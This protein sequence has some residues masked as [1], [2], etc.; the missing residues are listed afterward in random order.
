MSTELGAT[1]TTRLLVFPPFRFDPATE[2]LWLGDER[3]PLRPKTRA[4]LVYL[5]E[6]RHRIVSRAELCRAIW[7]GGHGTEHAPKQCIRELRTVFNDQ[8]DA[9]R[10]VQT[11]GRDGYQFIGE[12]EQNDEEAE[13]EAIDAETQPGCVGRDD[14]LAR[15]SAALD[16]VR[17]GKHITLILRGE[18]GVG[19]STL[20]D[21][22]T[23]P[24]EASKRFWVAHAECADSPNGAEPYAPLIVALSRLAR[25]PGATSVISSLERYAPSWLAQIPGLVSPSQY[26]RLERRLQATTSQRM[27]RELAQVFEDL[28]ATRCGVLILEDLQWCDAATLDW[29]SAW[30]RGRDQA[31]LLIIGT[32]RAEENIPQPLRRVLEYAQGNAQTELIELTGLNASM[33]E[34]YLSTRYASAALTPLVARTLYDRTRGHP[35]FLVA[36]LEDWQARGMLTRE[37]NA[38][39]VTSDI[40]EL[41]RTIPENVTQLIEA[42]LAGLDPSA[43]RLLEA[44]SAA[45]ATF[46][47]ATVA[48]ALNAPLDTVEDAC[49]QLSRQHLF[50]EET[51]TEEWM[52][53]TLST[54]YEFRHALYQ[55]ALAARMPAA[56]RAMAHRRI[57]KRLEAAYGPRTEH[58][59]ADLAGHFEAGHDTLR[60]AH[61][62]R[63]AGEVS[64]RRHAPREAAQYLR[65]AITL[66]AR[67]RASRS[68]DALE[69]LVELG[70]A[71]IG[72]EGFSSDAVA[73]TYR[74]AYALCERRANVSGSIPVLCGLWNYYLTRA[75]FI[76]V[77]M[78]GQRLSAAI[79]RAPQTDRLAAH[80]ALGQTHLFRG[81]PILALPH[82]AAVLE[83]YGT[84]RH[85]NVAVRYGE[86]PGV[87]CHEYAALT[88]WLTG[89]RAKA[90]DHLT[91][92]MCLAHELAQPGSIAQMLWMSALIAQLEGNAAHVLKLATTLVEHCKSH[93]V[94]QWLS[95]G[96][97]FQG[98]ALCIAGQHDDGMRELHCGIDSWAASGARLTRPYSLALLADVHAGRGDT[99][100]AVSIIDVALQ[101][102]EE[103]GEHWYTAA[104]YRLKGEWLSRANDT[105]ASSQAP[106]CLEQALHIARRQGARSFEQAAEAAHTRY[107]RRTVG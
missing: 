83:R 51:G 34:T 24:L 6:H 58:I 4:V 11:A 46:A 79:E 29:L 52:D 59:A 96:K 5:I 70:G 94:M 45:G 101:E 39:H 18:P 81:E 69:T 9:P 99:H 102:S 37:A 15:F 20:V 38:W 88:E 75:N 27:L 41:A 61:Y 86:D 13:E 95:G 57:A 105:A 77:D 36:L 76:A 73:R 97:M 84:T 63:R 62:N 98:W 87:V 14:E 92:G 3:L 64:M 25:Q 43:Q 19:K 82:I 21:T 100:A 42:R 22:F 78:L 26:A 53:G 2:A 44:A 104:L 47:A 90:H 10:F 89:E 56:R 35:L 85:V 93:D 74:R 50:L 30:V 65:K 80:N 23:A 28:T 68:A 40:A 72:A 66:L 49:A 60:A 54:R 107:A 31:R 12:I 8:A 55:E 32:M 106:P 103:T 16:K 67:S 7:P 71:L 17:R 33:V 91:Q 1:R 48:A